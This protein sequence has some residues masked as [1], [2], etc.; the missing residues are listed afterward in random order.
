VVTV[1]LKT[2]ESVPDGAVYG[3]VRVSP[4]DLKYSFIYYS[5]TP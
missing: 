5:F 4:S 2:I 3:I 1:S